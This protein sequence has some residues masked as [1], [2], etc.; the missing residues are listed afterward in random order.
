M[1]EILTLT[2]VKLAMCFGLAFVVTFW[3]IPAIVDIARAKSLFDEPNQR[4]SHTQSTPTLGGLAIFTGLALSTLLFFDF[5]AIPK[6]QYAIAG[7]LIIFFT[8][9]KDDLIGMT[10][11]KKFAAQLVAILIIVTVGDIRFSSLHGFIGIFGM[12]YNVGV[13]ISVIAIVGITNCFNLMDGID[14]LS[15][16]L[17]ILASLTFGAWFYLVGEYDWAMLCI[18]LTGAL[19]AFFYFNV[20]SKRHKIFMGDT[21]SLIL[22]YVM[23]IM[24]IK[25]NEANVDLSG[26]FYIRAAPAVSIGIMMVPVFDTLRVF[27]MRIFRNVSPFSPDKTHIHHYLL[28]LG[29]SHFQATLVLFFTG[30]IFVVV[31]FLLRHLTVAWLLM[32]LVAMGSVLSLIPILWVEKVKKKRER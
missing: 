29:L 23:A 11:F 18:G 27:V 10:P 31:A 6:F 12:N 1:N 13:I 25:F 2:N 21:G 22:G 28:E 4:A 3:L 7:L 15:A 24:A 17:G 30:V 16:S 8:G 14:G 9:I 19:L 5:T 32:I 20:F 26:P